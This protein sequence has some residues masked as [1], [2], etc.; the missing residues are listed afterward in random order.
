M[1][2][3]KAERWQRTYSKSTCRRFST[4]PNY[5]FGDGNAGW[6]LS[7]EGGEGVTGIN[8][9]GIYSNLEIA[10][11][12]R[13]FGTFWNEVVISDVNSNAEVSP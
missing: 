3:L 8:N 4:S 2:S 7:E 10:W 13:G 12:L 5:A 1:Q 9:S 11:V 6:P